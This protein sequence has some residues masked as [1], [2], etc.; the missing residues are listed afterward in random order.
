MRNPVRDLIDAGL[1]PTI[2]EDVAADDDIYSY[3]AAFTKKIDSLAAGLNPN[4]REVGKQI[5]MSKDTAVYQ[6]L[7]RIT[8][9]SDFVAR[10]S[11]YQHVTQ[12][13]KNPLSKLDAIQLASDSFVNYDIPLHRGLQYLDDMGI[14]MFTKYFLYIQRVL[15]KLGRDRPVQMLAAAA[16]HQYYGHMNIIT[17]S[18]M[19]Y[20]VPSNPFHMGPL[21]VLG[22]PGE[23]PAVQATWAL[24][25]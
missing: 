16:L 25:N 15:L 18:A 20:R 9:L 21:E 10:Y 8:Q 12:R 3:K 5:Y 1:M 7:S 19:I 2:A 11:L 17:D 22:A 4:V 13:K 23:L 6:S 14:T 24:L